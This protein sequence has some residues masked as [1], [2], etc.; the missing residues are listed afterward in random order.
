MKYLWKPYHKAVVELSQ[1]DLESLY[2]GKSDKIVCEGSPVIVVLEKHSEA[3]NAVWN[4]IKHWDADTD[5]QGYH[6]ITGTDIRVILD[7]LKMPS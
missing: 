4:A 2:F 6:G 5:G 3:F 7:A 1:E